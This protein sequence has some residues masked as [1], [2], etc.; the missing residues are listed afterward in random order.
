MGSVFNDLLL[1]CVIAVLVVKLALVLH[2]QL[3][4]HF[5][6]H[7]TATLQSNAIML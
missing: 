6:W 1:T 2:C 4:F 7:Y 5:V 3:C